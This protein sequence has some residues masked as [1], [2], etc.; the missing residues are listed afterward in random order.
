MC[1]TK[2]GTMGSWGKRYKGT[3]GEGK[4]R[5]KELTGQNTRGALFVESKGICKGEWGQIKKE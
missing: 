3:R 1:K 5:L 2:K 4:E